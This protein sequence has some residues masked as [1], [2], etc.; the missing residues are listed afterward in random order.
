MMRGKLLSLLLASLFLWGCSGHFQLISLNDGTSILGEY[1]TRNHFMKVTMPDG[2]I[3]QGSYSSLTGSSIGSGSL[4]YP[5]KTL[6]PLSPAT[7]SAS[8]AYALLRGDNG[9]VMEMVL[10]YSELSGNG[11][12]VAST[13][14]GTGYRVVFPVLKDA[15]A[16]PEG[17]PALSKSNEST[18][19]GDQKAL[20]WL[21]KSYL[22]FQE[23]DWLQVTKAASAA[24]ERDPTLEGA[25]RNRAWAYYKQGLFDRS[26][27]DCTTVI[28][29]DPENVL[30]YNYR[31]LSYADKGMYDPALKDLDKAFELNGKD[32]VTLNNRG[33]VFER[34]GDKMEALRDYKTSCEFGFGLA[35]ENYRKI[36]G[37]HPA[38]IAKKVNKL[39]D[40][41]NDCFQKG[42]LDC[43]IAKTSEALK[44]DSYNVVAYTNR[45]G[46]Y[47]SKRMF[48][49]AAE[50][51]DKAIKIKP[52]FGLAY[53]NRGYMYQL[54]GQSG[55]AKSDYEKACNLGTAKAC[56]NLKILLQTGD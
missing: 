45:A 48:N 23:N 21:G 1:Q 11:H 15:A 40:E 39:V 53:N 42:D 12:G 38:D 36:A 52:D 16:A 5:A 50:D 37:A 28:R 19:K 32:P 7:D 20:E 13:N 46:A 47:A 49:E 31:G 33:V 30:A 51:S 2:E 18:G 3:L 26:I 35:C 24:I 14:K 8:E 29:L 43:A 55:Q 17:K 6:L 9:T 27:K 41:S 25:Y 44:L 56:E 34:K 4:L 54:A 22:A 10:R